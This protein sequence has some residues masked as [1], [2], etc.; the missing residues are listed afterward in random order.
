MTIEQI[1][2]SS[3]RQLHFTLAEFATRKARALELMQEQGLEA[4]LMFRQES[5]YYLTG[6]DTM[7]YITFQCMLLHVSGHC[8]LLTRE[9]DRRAARLT[10]IIE[11]VRIYPDDPA[12]NP[13]D[14]LREIAEEHGLRGRR[15]GIEYNAFG[16]NAARARMVERAFDGFCELIDASEVI[17]SLRI[18]KSP[19]ELRYVETAARIADLALERAIEMARP[20]VSEGELLGA[21]QSEVFLNGGDFAASRWILGCGDHAMLVRHF[22]GH[23]LKLQEEDQL[24]LEFGAAYLHYHACLFHTLYTGK[25]ADTQKRMHEAAVESLM[26]VREACRPGAVVGDMFEQY[27]RVA[28]KFGMREFRLNAC[29]YSLGATYPP[30]WMDGALIC[31]GNT[32]PVE[33]DMVFF[34]HMVFLDSDRRFTAC[35]GETL[36]VTQSGCRPLST[37]PFKLYTT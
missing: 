37:V 2:R 35:A 4:I 14:H 5:M 34:P 7:G 16:L 30:T 21:M 6:Y 26:S 19:A 13:A 24:Q 22:T 23:H 27:A 10:S 33:Q 32:T 11:D 15:V 1:A 12:T 31:R 28:E 3:G 9:P 36:V 18:R 17:S 29:G 20:G 8:T 25:V